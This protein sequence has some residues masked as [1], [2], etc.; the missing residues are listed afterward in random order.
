MCGGRARW[1]REVVE[2]HKFDYVDI[3]EFYD[4]RCFTKFK[5]T[6]VFLVNAYDISI[7]I[8]RFLPCTLFV[9]LFLKSVLVYAADMQ[10]AVFLL[11]HNKWSSASVEP[12]IPFEISKWI[13][14][15][16]IIFSFLLLGYDFFRARAII[17]SRDIAYAFTSVVAYRFYVL[18]SYPHFCFFSKIHE[19]KTRSDEVAFF[20]F[21]MLKGWKRLFIAEGPRQVIAGFTLYALMEENKFSFEFWKY[22]TMMQSITMSLMVFTLVV[23]LGTV[24]QVVLALLI[25]P[26]LLCHI[27]GN[28]KEY[29][30]HKIDKRIG[31]LLR[32]RTRKRVIKEMQAADHA[33]SLYEDKKQERKATLPDVNRI[34]A[35]GRQPATMKY[36]P[37]PSR[38][39]VAMNIFR[40]AADMTHLASIFIL[41]LKMDKTRSVAGISFKTQLFYA[42]VFITRYLDLF[43]SFIS[44]YNTLM[45][46]FFI[47]SSLYILYLMKFR[48][49]ATFDPALD[50]FRA[51]F[52]LVPCALLALV[53][54]YRFTFLEVLWAFSIYL[55]AV[56]ILPQLFMLTRTGEAETITTHYLFALGMYR[57]L[58]LLN[59]VYRYATEPDYVDWIVWIAG[60]V[61][62]ALYSDFFYVYYKKVLKGNRFTMPV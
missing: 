26:F 35:E 6:F 57:T 11:I 22:N 61:Q 40:L 43:T 3:D 15:G 38:K 58:Y 60:S 24:V 5:Y 7:F 18:R 13:F 49:K 8:F 12:K 27:Q 41:L 19:V 44:I 17:R 30:C 47:G 1:K 54:N 39:F 34:L 59:W 32:K 46:L 14:V 52:L 9:K 37:P 23:W 45:K 29:C 62:T 48:Y 55:E 50:T 53:V 28:L 56:A 42:I 25:Y 21:F 16:C 51:E 36:P 33:R 20:V 2:E 4:S 31:E 10:T